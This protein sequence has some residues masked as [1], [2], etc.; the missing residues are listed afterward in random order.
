MFAKFI[1]NSGLTILH[2]ETESCFYRSKD[3]LLSAEHHSSS[4]TDDKSTTIE[5]LCFMDNDIPFLN[6]FPVIL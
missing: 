5:G 6:V 2:L 4:K 3:A 1:I